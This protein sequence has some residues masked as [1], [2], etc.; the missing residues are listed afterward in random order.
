MATKPTAKLD[1]DVGIQATGFGKAQKER[2][3][4]YHKMMRFITGELN[5]FMFVMASFLCVLAILQLLFL[6]FVTQHEQ[7]SISD[8]SQFSC[9]A[10]SITENSR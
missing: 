4:R 6:I 3:Y 9:M 7:I 8:G 5:Q 2:S 10:D 1:F